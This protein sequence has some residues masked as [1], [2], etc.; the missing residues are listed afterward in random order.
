MPIST[1]AEAKTLILKHMVDG[2]TEWNR[3][4]LEAFIICVR[5]EFEQETIENVRAARRI[6]RNERQ[7]I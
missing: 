3:G 5:H 7:Y 1:V 4:I 6:D 2:D